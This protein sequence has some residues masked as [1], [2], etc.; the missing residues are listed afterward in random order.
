ML[1]LIPAAYGRVVNAKSVVGTD[2]QALLT[3][4]TMSDLL[5]RTNGCSI[6]VGLTQINLNKPGKSLALPSHETVS[7]NRFCTFEKAE[8]QAV[9]L[10]RGTAE[11]AVQHWLHAAQGQLR[12]SWAMSF[13][14]AYWR[15]WANKSQSTMASIPSLSSQIPLAISLHRWYPTDCSLQVVYWCS[16]CGKVAT[17]F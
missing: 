9:F 10:P 12:P 13:N 2:P 16:F 8:F 14:W 1:S 11:H 3:L 17:A 6:S 5:R 4:G 15:T 7:P